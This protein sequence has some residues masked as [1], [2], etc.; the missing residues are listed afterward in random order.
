MPILLQLSVLSE[1]GIS[2][3]EETEEHKKGIKGKKKR[4]R[5]EIGREEEH[6]KE[7]RE[8]R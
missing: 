1:R 4:T 5:E 7:K 8:K 2:G 6:M 3:G